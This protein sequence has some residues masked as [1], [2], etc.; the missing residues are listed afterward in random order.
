MILPNFRY[1][2]L[3][4]DFNPWVG[5]NIYLPAIVGNTR[6]LEILLTGDVYPACKMLE[7]RFLNKIVPSNGRGD[8][9]S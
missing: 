5:G 6:A 8:G 3:N 9:F 4:W 1:A 2:E 7:W